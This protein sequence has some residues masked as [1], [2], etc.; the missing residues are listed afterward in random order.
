LL[1]SNGDLAT[2]MQRPVS[3][4][5]LVITVLVLLAAAI[6]SKIFA[7]RVSEPVSE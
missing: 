5:F 3:S 6:A 1:L 7:K 4:I 2:F